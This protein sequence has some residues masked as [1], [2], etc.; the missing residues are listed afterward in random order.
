MSGNAHQDCNYS[1]ISVPAFSGREI[2]FGKDKKDDK[3]Q[4]AACTKKGNN[5]RSRITQ[6]LESPIRVIC[7]LNIVTKFKLVSI[8]L[9]VATMRKHKRIGKIMEPGIY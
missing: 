7:M 6:G 5:R 8:I 9:S 3:D 1:A 4:N 2:A